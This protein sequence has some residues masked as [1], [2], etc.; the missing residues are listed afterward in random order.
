MRQFLGVGIYKKKPNFILR[1]LWNN[2]NC[3]MIAEPI[4]HLWLLPFSVFGTGHLWV[5]LTLERSSLPMQLAYALQTT[6]HFWIVAQAKVQA[7]DDCIL[8][9]NPN[10]PTCNVIRSGWI[11][12]CNVCRFG[13]SKVCPLDPTQWKRWSRCRELSV[14][15]LFSCASSYPPRS[16][17]RAGC[18]RCVVAGLAP[19]CDIHFYEDGVNL[20]AIDGEIG[21]TISIWAWPA[22]AKVDSVIASDRM[23]HK[24]FHQDT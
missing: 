5:D 19:L 18:G 2:H 23:V 24:R 17:S 9:M 12:I 1:R 13:T 10:L 14:Y 16:R 15:H 11:T 20:L 22:I 8:K 7:T 4:W 6:W 21:T 3:A